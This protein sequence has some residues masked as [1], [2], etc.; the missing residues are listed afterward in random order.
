MTKKKIVKTIKKNKK[1]IIIAGICTGTALLTAG[2]IKGIKSMKESAKAQH[3]VDKAEFEAV[4]A[5]SKANFEE[6]RVQ[7]KPQSQQDTNSRKIA[8]AEERRKNAE[9]RIAKT[10]E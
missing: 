4:K 9:D 3:E 10:K 1:P 7:G 6:A 8:Q 2:I 5:E